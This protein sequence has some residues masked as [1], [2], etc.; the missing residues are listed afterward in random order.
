MQSSEMKPFSRLRAYFCPIYRSEFPKFIPLFWLAFFVGFNYC[1]LKSMKDTLVVVGSDAGAEVIP[2]LKVWGIVPG[3]VIVTMVYGWLSNRCPR[4]T[5]FY[6]FIGTFLGFFFLFAVVIYPMGDAIH[7]HS[8]AD[9]LQELLPQGLRGFIVMI[10]YWSYSLYYVMSELWSSVILSTL[11]W[12]LANEVTSIKEA[13]RFYALI[14][15][16]LNLSSVFAGEISYWMGKHTFFVFPFVKDKWH[17]VMLNLTMLIVLAG[18]SMIWLYRKVHLLT[19]HT[20]NFSAYSSSEPVTEELSQVEES[21]ASAKAKKKTKAKAKNLFLYLIRSRYLLGLAI[22]VLSYN[23]VIHLFEVVWKDQVSQIY[24]SH[25]EFNSYMSRITTLIGIVSVLAAIF[26]TGQS[27]RKW[28]WTVGALTTPIVMLVTGVLF[29]GAIFAVKRDVMIFGGL[30]NTAPM[31]IA[32]WIGGMQNVFSRAAKFTFFDQTKE[33]AFVPLPNDQKNF[34]KAAIDGV[35]SRIGKSGGSLIY[36]GLLIIFSSVAASL[37]VI[38]VVLLL[39]MI[40]WIAVVAFIGREYN[41]K[42]AAAVAA[43]L[44]ADPMVSDV[45]ISKTTGENSNQEEVAT[46]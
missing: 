20:Y 18:L 36:Q 41:I 34:G 15:T 8:V 44:D 4:D 21:V 6:S 28:G 24:S 35:V 23:L 2:F 29:F 3:A 39:I 11:F 33:M 27:I 40:V 43:S 13:G 17:E 10:R 26:L 12:G 9:R 25:V 1:L 32:A 38:A 46:L 5:V 37:N 31:V 7:L 42:E 30:F 19:K 16:G 45:A 14:N 22:I